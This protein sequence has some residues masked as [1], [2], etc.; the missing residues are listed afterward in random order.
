[1]EHDEAASGQE[2]VYVVVKGS[3]HWRIGDTEVGVRVG[4]FVRIDPETPRCPI[5]G[6][7][8]MSFISIGARRGSYEPPRPLLITDC[9]IRASGAKRTRPSA[10]H[11]PVLLPTAVGPA[12]GRAMFV[13]ALGSETPSEA[14]PSQLEAFLRG[15]VSET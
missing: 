13:C 1:M 9:S 5:A 11:R 3:G 4:S 8:G 6:Q 12:S 10:Y 14:V 2:E 7:D 15:S